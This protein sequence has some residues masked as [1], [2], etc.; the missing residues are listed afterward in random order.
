M[1]RRA[2]QMG[3]TGQRGFTL[4]ELLITLVLLTFLFA[5]LTMVIN[6]AS[7]TFGDTLSLSVTAE[8]T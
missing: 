8:V 2:L 6:E 1:K 5:K 7:K 4:I 3:Q